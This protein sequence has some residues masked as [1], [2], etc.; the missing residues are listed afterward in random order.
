M[1]RFNNNGNKVVLIFISDLIRKIFKGDR[2]KRISNKVINIAKELSKKNKKK[3]YILDYGCGSMEVSKKLLKKEFVK[4]IIGTDIFHHKFKKNNI[5]Y[6][7]KNKL[8]ASKNIRF[9]LIISID[10]LHH[11]GVERSHKI[12][13]KLSKY[14]KY[15]LIKRSL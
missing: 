13:N 9:D 14:S 10:V 1:I 6:I 7:Q 12:L 4:R 2:I 15:I 5:E 11:I 3:F 8:F